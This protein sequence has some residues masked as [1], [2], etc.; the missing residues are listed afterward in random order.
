MTRAKRSRADA[1]SSL[2]GALPVAGETGQ[3]VEIDRIRVLPGQPRR[4][5]DVEAMESLTESIREQG[6][7]QPVLVRPASGG[8]E[9]IAGERRLRAAT[10][11]GLTQIPVVIREV[12][13]DDVLLVA[14]LENL[15]RQDLN[16]LD[17][18][19]A[20][21]TILARELDVATEQVVPLL[22]A[23]R[24][25]PH[26]ETTDRI[27]QVFRRLG[28]GGW[29]SFTANKTGVL[30]FPT[31]LLDL[32]RTGRLE[33]TRAAA[34]AKVKDAER[35]H[36]LTQQALSDKLSVREINEL[37]KP[38]TLSPMPYQTIKGLIEPRRIEQLGK[39]DRARVDK[40]LRELEE[41]LTSD[42]AFR[43]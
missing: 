9:L 20:T 18:V 12:P 7:L 25:K 38:A 37:A 30:K 41:I 17:E 22:H 2:L 35:R 3:T 28:R 5:F 26:T 15:Q 4:V 29:Q 23:Q 13:D 33:Y 39:K 10:A 40:L 19:E 11:A 36:Q 32:M 31:E 43:S 14:A 27:E 16:P 6:V 24:R 1:F 21:V 42:A 8:F 34:L